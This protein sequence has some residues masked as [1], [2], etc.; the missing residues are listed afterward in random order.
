MPSCPTCR[1]QHPHSCGNNLFISLNIPCAI[2]LEDVP[3]ENCWS[4]PCGHTFSK[5]SLRAMGFSEKQ[6][7][8]RVIERV[9]VR[10]VERPLILDENLADWARC[11]NTNDTH[12]FV[13][14]EATSSYANDI[15]S[16]KCRNCHCIH[17]EGSEIYKETNRY[18]RNR[19]ENRMNT[20]HHHWQVTG[21]NYS[22]DM[23]FETCSLCQKVRTR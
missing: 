15:E 6:D 14:D 4:L 5:E 1:K 23:I 11:P 10:E 13:F 22:M 2:T 18:L 9:V 7:T 20:C 21:G 16:Y 8:P 3:S 17:N 12:E 19:T